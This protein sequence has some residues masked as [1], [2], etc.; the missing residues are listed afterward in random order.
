MWQTKSGL[1]LFKGDHNSHDKLVEKTLR[2][3]TQLT[4]AKEEVV[5]SLFSTGNNFKVNNIKSTVIVI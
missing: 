1:W 3:L 4:K 2:F 5:Q